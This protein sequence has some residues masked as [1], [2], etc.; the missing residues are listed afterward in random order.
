[1]E[2]TTSSSNVPYIR[3]THL[4]NT[5]EAHLSEFLSDVSHIV[6]HCIPNELHQ[7]SLPYGTCPVH[8]QTTNQYPRLRPD[9]P[10]LHKHQVALRSTSPS[11]DSDDDMHAL[12]ATSN[13]HINKCDGGRK[14]GSCT[15][16]TCHVVE[17]SSFYSADDEH[18]ERIKYL[19]KHRG[20]VVFPNEKGHG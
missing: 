13:L 1:M 18:N 6:N 2:G 17:K 7:Q 10:P 5:M 3:N 19:L 11:G 15:V 14:L 12:Y 16:H 9:A 20:L 8:L 4:S